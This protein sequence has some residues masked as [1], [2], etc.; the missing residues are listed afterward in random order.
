MSFRSKKL[1]DSAEGQSCVLCEK[2]DGTTVAAHANSVALGKG[3][4]IKPPD[5]YTAHVCHGCHDLI[6]G[7]AGKLS[8]EEKMEMWTRAFVRTVARWFNQGIVGVK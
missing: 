4:G 1:L 3:K 5:Y 7:R 6:D 8:K 2:E